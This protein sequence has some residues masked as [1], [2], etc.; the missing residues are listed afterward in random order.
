MQGPMDGGMDKRI[1]ARI[2]PALIHHQ[3]HTPGNVWLY[4]LCPRPT[5]GAVAQSLLT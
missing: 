2:T 4:I 5:A 1:H 3:S